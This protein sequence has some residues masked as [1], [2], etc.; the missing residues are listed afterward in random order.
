M[1]SIKVIVLKLKVLIPEAVVAKCA[2]TESFQSFPLSQNIT[3]M[4]TNGSY[5]L[6]NKQ[7][8]KK[9]YKDKPTL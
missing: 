4:P 9:C 3:Y 5:P 2:I 6:L 1:K 7:P 8:T